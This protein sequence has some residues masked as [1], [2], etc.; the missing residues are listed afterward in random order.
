MNKTLKIFMC[1][2][3]RAGGAGCISP[4]AKD[5]LSALIEQASARPENIEVVQITCMGYC[6]KGPNVKIKGG[7]YFHK[8]QVDGVSDILDAVGSR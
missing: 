7:A 8:V 2:N 4:G 5:V 6:E 3:Q 1:G